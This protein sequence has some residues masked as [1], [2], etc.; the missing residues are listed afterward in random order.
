MKT[1][2]LGLK[3][4]VLPFDSALTG[5]ICEYAAASVLLHAADALTYFG[6][7]LASI[8]A[9]AVETA[10][11]LLYYS[12]LR[13]THALLARHGV[14]VLAQ[15]N[16]VVTAGGTSVEIPI[17]DTRIRNNGHQSLWVAFSAWTR[18][19]KTT[20]F[21]GREISVAGFS[22]D[23]WVS[24]R[25][26]STPLS[27]VWPSLLAEWGLDLE[28]F[29]ADRDSR[30]HLSY[31]PTRLDVS[32]VSF[33]PSRVWQ[34]ISDSWELLEPHA[35]NPFESIDLF[36]FREVMETLQL[37]SN[38]STKHL[39][40]ASYRTANQK[41]VDS[42][43]GPGAGGYLVDLLQRPY[44]DATPQ[45]LLNAKVDPLG[46]VPMSRKMSGM[47]GRDLILLRAALGAATDLVMRSGAKSSDLDFWKDD[48]L[49]ERGVAVPVGVSHLRDMY[50]DVI[51]N[52]NQS[53]GM[54]SMTTVS[55]LPIAN[56]TYAAELAE[57]ARLEQV[58]AWAVA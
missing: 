34:Y 8:S 43:L 41:L 12:E 29:G 24:S 1:P 31:D 9:G 46:P 50:A 30:N 49:S 18:D 58:A 27:S 38:P 56:V 6:R 42:V 53:A 22:L 2:R 19:P 3:G 4:S 54:L 28:I 51:A 35:G 32:P 55:D 15:K 23:R 26:T 10:Q 16:F 36:L 17:R 11:H 33:P 7:A 25:S 44:V 14:L 52:L 57:L 48:L 37:V 13:A 47:I 5:R 40:T 21:F 45:H 39:R 20:D